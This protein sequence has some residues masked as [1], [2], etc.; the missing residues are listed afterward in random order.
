MADLRDSERG[1]GEQ[2]ED[3]R[4][5]DGVPDTHGAMNAQPSRQVAGR[6]GPARPYSS[7]VVAGSVFC[8]CWY[9]GFARKNFVIR[10]MRSLVEGCCWVY[11]S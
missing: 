2:R 5:D 9:C 6:L 8:Q 11:C 3:G 1:D 4:G 7:P 10:S